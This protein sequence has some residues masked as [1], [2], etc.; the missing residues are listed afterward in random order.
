MKDPQTQE[1]YTGWYLTLI[2]SLLVLIFLFDRFTR[3][4]S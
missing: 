2:V 1:S 4:F 3:F